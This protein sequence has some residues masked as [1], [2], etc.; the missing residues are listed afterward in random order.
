MIE[1]H[2]H[3]A[4]GLS[5]PEALRHAQRAVRRDP[6]YQNPFYWAPFVVVGAP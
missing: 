3:L 2:R 5:K 4:E 1:F 6:R